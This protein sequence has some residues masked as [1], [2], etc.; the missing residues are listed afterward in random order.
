MATPPD[1]DFVALQ[2]AARAGDQ[3][4][5]TALYHRFAPAVRAMFSHHLDSN[6]PTLRLLHDSQD[7][8][9]EVLMEFFKCLLGDRTFDHPE[10]VALYLQ[11]LTH[12]HLVDVIR[13]AQTKRL[14][15][16][17]RRL[18]LD[19][20]SLDDHPLLVSREPSPSA[21]AE[22]AETLQELLTR[23][24]KRYQRIVTLKAG[25]RTI[26]EIAFELR[27]SE[28]LVRGIIQQMR[29][30]AAVPAA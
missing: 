5:C 10:R 3:K 25:G 8:Q 11:I 30:L 16:L 21:L 15:F 20:P 1:A 23:L 24:P 28:R 18:H 14:N 13:R 9:Q 4:A 7:L 29:D 26:K 12:S 27:I 19:D 2:Q 17:V 6:A 22:A